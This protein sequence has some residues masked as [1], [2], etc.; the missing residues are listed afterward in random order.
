[1]WRQKGR[2]AD[3]LRQQDKHLLQLGNDKK[4]GCTREDELNILYGH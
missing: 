1:M 4:E 3:K 2:R